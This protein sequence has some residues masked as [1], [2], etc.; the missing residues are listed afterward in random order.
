MGDSCRRMLRANDFFPDL[1]GRDLQGLPWHSAELAGQIVALWLCADSA[2]HQR[3]ASSIARCSA[4]FLG[5]I[6]TQVV[7]FAGPESLASPA[8]A[9]LGGAS[10][11]A[12]FFRGA[13][14]EPVLCLLRPD[15]KIAWMG[16]LSATQQDERSVQSLRNAVRDLRL[17]LG[18]AR[19]PPALAIEQA[20]P[21]S[22]CGELVQYFQ[23]SAHKIQG[24][25]GLSA[26]Q[27][28]ASRKR[29]SHVNLDCDT[30]KMVDRELVY[31]MLPMIERCFD[32]RVTRRVAYK[33]ALYDAADAGF[34]YAHRDNSDPGTRYRRYALSLALN[35]DWQG[36]GLCFPEFGP[37]CHRIGVGNALV[38]PVS[39]LHQVHPVERGQR[40]M[41]LSFLYDEPA[42]R[43]RRAQMAE[44][45][46]LDGV[47]Q[48]AIDPDLLYEY[49]RN[50]APSSRFAPS[51]FPEES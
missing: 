15:G 41:L 38:F 12:L 23:D 1:A 34:F 4:A 32:F 28:D 3:L 40:F 31:T 10:T 39:L 19:M 11:R 5:G 43:D 18:H 33:L 6:H 35:D 47:Y 50:Y 14:A 45:G 37:Q 17:P 44:P 51:F 30:A 26:P 42:A 48:D 9:L 22:L 20:L 2:S 8:V 16:P 21:A 27:L 36:G 25:V 24:R 29:V 49:D 13:A 7:I 46:L